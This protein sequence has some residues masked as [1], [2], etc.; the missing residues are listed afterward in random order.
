LANRTA[1][2]AVAAALEGG[3]RYQQRGIRARHLAQ[4]LLSGFLRVFREI[5]VAAK[6]RR[7]DLSM[8]SQCLLERPAGTDGTCLKSRADSAFFFSAD[9]GKKLIQIVNDASFLRHEKLLSG[10]LPQ[11]GCY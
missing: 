6:Q 11:S 5:V 7:D 9:L 2:D 1:R 10:L 3:P 8:F 4:Q